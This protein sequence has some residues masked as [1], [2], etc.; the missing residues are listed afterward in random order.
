MFS[1]QVA[2]SITSKRMDTESN[3]WK[4][5]HTSEALTLRG[6]FASTRLLASVMSF[7]KVPQ[8][9]RELNQSKSKCPMSAP[10]QSRICSPL[11]S[12]KLA[13]GTLS[14]IAARS[15]VV[16]AA[17]INVSSGIGSPQLPEA[18]LISLCQARRLRLESR[19]AA[20]ITQMGLVFVYGHPSTT[21]PERQAHDCSMTHVQLHPNAYLPL[22][23]RLPVPLISSF[24]WLTNTLL[25]FHMDQPVSIK[26]NSSY[27][28][29]H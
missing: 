7:E 26:A 3:V 14:T 24:D 9:N 16:V 18:N 10:V 12:N 20:P 4:R 2:S 21:N 15:F 13:Y 23:N 22:P 27:E 29:E 11:K 1:V 17:A 5:T 6:P 25:Y 8:L 19:P 28:H